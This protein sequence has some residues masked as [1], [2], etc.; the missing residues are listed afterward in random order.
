MKVR[1]K[2]QKAKTIEGSSYVKSSKNM[3]LCIG[4]INAVE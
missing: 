2:K 3:R 4:D 1:S